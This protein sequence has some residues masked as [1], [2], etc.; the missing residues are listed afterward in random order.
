MLI[1]REIQYRK[2]KEDSSEF[3]DMH[4]SWTLIKKKNSL[5]EFCYN[6]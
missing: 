2:S 5:M 3:Q 1:T 4:G 6:M